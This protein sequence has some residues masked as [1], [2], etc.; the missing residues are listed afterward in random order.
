MEAISPGYNGAIAFHTNRDGTA[1]E[2]YR[3]NSDGGHL[4]NLTNSTAHESEPDWSSDGQL[5]TYTSNADGPQEIYS[6]SADGANVRKLTNNSGVDSLPKWSPEGNRIIFK[7]A[8]DGN[9]EIY[10]MNADG[11]DQTRL[12]NDPGNDSSANWSPD[13][14]KIV[15]TSDRGGKYQIHIM[16]PDGTNQTNVSNNAFREGGPRWSPNGERIIFTSDRSGVVGIY[17]MDT[18]GANVTPVVVSGF[19]N[20]QPN[21][22]PDGQYIAFTSQRDGNQEI[23]F[24]R[25][26]GSDQMR[27]TNNASIDAAPVWQPIPNTPPVVAVDVLS[28]QVNAAST[29]DVLANDAD[30]E[31]LDPANLTISTSPAHGTATIEAGKIKYTPAAHYIGDDQLIYKICDSFLLDQKCATGVLGITVQAGPAPAVPTITSVGTV[32]VNGQTKVYYTGHRPTCAGTAAPDSTITV[33]IH[34][35]PITLTTT[36]DNQG[37]WSVTPDRDLPNGDH[38][39]TITSTK[40]GAS[41]AVLTFVLGINVGLAET[42]VPIWPLSAAGILVLMGTRWSLKRRTPA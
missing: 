13:G 21:W 16:N 2:I 29:I 8:R 30:E 24:A 4:Q 7:S 5:L 41:S 38:T 39:V 9:S 17:A 3:I 1:Y 25:A 33:D 34:S 40:D 26:D 6:S 11:T 37:H 32:Q 22:S 31:A 23:Y 27:L 19:I 42:G 10:V 15:F 14:S 36:V 20:T 12:T 28:L 35:D 18:D